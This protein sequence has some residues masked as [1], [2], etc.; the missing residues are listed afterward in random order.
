MRRAT[1]LLVL[2]LAVAAQSQP[3]GPALRKLVQPVAGRPHTGLTLPPHHALGPVLPGLGQGAVPQ[4]LAFW[5]E[6][7]WFLVSFY[8]EKDAAGRAPASVVAAID[9]G[10]K[11]V[12][13]CLTLV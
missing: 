9:A 5:K 12:V 1:L 6:R 13:R 8:F 4:G 10:T 7:N 2:I 3:A 11:R